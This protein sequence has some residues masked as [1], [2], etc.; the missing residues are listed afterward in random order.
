MEKK[1]EDKPKDEK[2]E[3]KPKEP[4]DEKKDEEK[5]KEPTEK[6]D[7][8]QPT[9]TPEKETPPSPVPSTPTQGS[10]ETCTKEMIVECSKACSPFD[11]QC[12][13]SCCDT[14]VPS[15]SCTPEIVA[16]CSMACANAEDKLSADKCYEECAKG[17][18]ELIK[19]PLEDEPCV[20]EPPVTPSTD[21]CHHEYLSLCSKGC[22]KDDLACFLECAKP[23]HYE[24]NPACSAEVI[25]QCTQRCACE[26]PGDLK[27]IKQC[28]LGCKELD[29]D[30][31]VTGTGSVHSSQLLVE[32]ITEKFVANP[33][34]CTTCE[35]KPAKKNKK[36]L[37]VL[38]PTASCTKCEEK[39]IKT[40]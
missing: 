25:S 7:E 5:P 30:I 9:K 14:C 22:K 38:P 26:A 34:K 37:P 18:G 33:E 28:V 11:S 27:C 10:N 4:K 1:D 36:K 3:D 23:C 19:I 20:E 12:F 15:K 24:S 32:S 31:Q 8:D 6:K 35:T 29:F 13:L 16:N 21:S 39:K 17:C 40:K 2:K